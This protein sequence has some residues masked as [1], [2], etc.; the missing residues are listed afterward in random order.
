MKVITIGRDI[1]NDVVIDD[2]YASRHH[3]QIVQCDD[4]TYKLAD[5]G[6]SNGTY[7]NGQKVEGEI[8]LEP[9]DIV[10]VG[11]TTIPWR[12]YFEQEQPAEELNDEAPVPETPVPETP[13][14]AAP[15]AKKEKKDSPKNSS[16]KSTIAI[17][18]T[19]LWIIFFGYRIINRMSRSSSYDRSRTNSA[20][21]DK[22]M[23]KRELRTFIDTI[24]NSAPYGDCFGQVNSFQFEDGNVVVHISIEDESVNRVEA[25]K[26]NEE[27]VAD[28]YMTIYSYPYGFQRSLLEMITEA[29][30]GMTF[31]F[32]GLDTNDSCKINVAAYKV[33]EAVNGKAVK[34]MDFILAENELL[35]TRIEN[36]GQDSYFKKVVIEGDYRVYYYQSED[37]VISYLNSI[38]EQRKKE[39]LD[40]YKSDNGDDVLKKSGLG[41]KFVFQNIRSSKK[42]VITIEN[43]EL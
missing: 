29:G 16:A 25:I 3:L 43:N 6:S 15:A 9:N 42:C 28:A 5:F 41:M 18:F 23:S 11:N 14:P 32:R 17:I 33:K 34:D 24:N 7:V 31:D 2:G 10:R 20:Y 12:I 30:C 13:V 35:N 1:D 21:T 37:Y 36:T 39:I 19:I 38:K 22:I 26:S 8:V 40:L 4:G 27:K